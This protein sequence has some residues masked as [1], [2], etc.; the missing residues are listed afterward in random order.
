MSDD[1]RI[2]LVSGSNRGLGYETL[3]QLAKQGMRVILTSRDEPRGQE[4]ARRLRSEVGEDRVVFHQLDVTDLG[5]VDRLYGF[6]KGHFGR[7]DVLV[8]NA[9]VFLDGGDP[10]WD[11]A[12]GVTCARIETLR[13]TMETN[14]YGP[15]RMIRTFMPLMKKRKYGRIVNVSS[16]MGQLSEMGGGY[17]AYRIS[18][19]ALNALTRIVSEEL[20]GEGI[21]VN[22]ACPGWVRTE[23][24]GPQGQRTPEQGADTIIWLATLPDDGPTGGFFRDRK[25][26][27]W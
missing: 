8:N 4:S 6:I 11:K 26:I 27:A 3:K 22:S 14:V 18:K 23:M 20:K 1:V 13:R 9:G 19:A 12:E 21:L 17:P 10:E 7:L 5:S 15:L 25:P 24:G 16:G 2:A